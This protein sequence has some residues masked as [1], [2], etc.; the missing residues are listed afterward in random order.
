[1]GVSG[2]GEGRGGV[3]KI[4]LY[5][6]DV[7]PCLQAV[8]GKGMAQVMEAKVRHELGL[9]ALYEQR[10][11]P[12]NLAPVEEPENENAW[13]DDPGAE[14]PDQP[15]SDDREK[16]VFEI[17]PD[18]AELSQDQHGEVDAEEDDDAPWYD[19]L[20]QHAVYRMLLEAN[21][22][23]SK[24]RLIRELKDE[25]L[26]RIEFAA[27]SMQDY[28][29]VVH[30][31]DNKDASAA[32]T[33]RNHEELRGDTPMEWKQSSKDFE[34][35]QHQKMLR[36]MKKADTLVVKSIDHLWCNYEEILAQVR[37]ITKE[38]GAAIVVLDMPL[39]DTRQNRDLTGT[40]IA[41]IVLHLLSYVAQTEREFI[42]QRQKEGIVAAIA[43][44]VKF[45][46]EPKT[47]H[48]SIIR[49]WRSGIPA[50]LSA[51]AAGKQLHV[52]HNTFLK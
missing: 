29:Q 21:R 10:L 52:S 36:K 48:R 34:R 28:E 13:W 32:R 40:L 31:W 3:S 43:R 30:F 4:L 14:P 41:D 51:C 42:R 39:L 22:Q 12:V 35:P 20:T 18:A 19:S 24:K 2:Q 47:R 33:Q 9:E 27:R 16:D 8:D 50:S 46:R 1:M 25:A 17:E 44:G 23:S 6:L 7:V 49:C 45:G 5:R 37:V 11:R 26:E 38:K 15:K